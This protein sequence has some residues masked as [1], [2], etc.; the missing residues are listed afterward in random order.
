MRLC[1]VLDPQ[2]RTGRFFRTL[3]TSFVHLG[4]ATVYSFILIPLI[5]HF[6]NTEKLGLW[7]LVA[8]MGAYLAVVDAG[9]SA[10]SIR[11]FV[12]PVSKGN[13]VGLTPR[14]QAT[15]VLSLAQ[16]LVVCLIGLSGPWFSIIFGISDQFKDLFCHLFLAQCVLVGIG[17][18]VRPFSSVL[19]AAQ[20]FDRNYL[21]SSAAFFCALLLTAWGFL[22]GWGLWSVILGSALQTLASAGAS[23]GGVRRMCRLSLLFT[24]GHLQP[25]LIFQIFRESTFF[26]GGSIFST[27]GGLWQSV[28]LSRIFGLEAVAAWNVGAKIAT[29]FSQIL[30]KFF[31]SAFAG[32][33]ELEERQQRSLVMERFLQI[34]LPSLT[35]TTLLS[36]LILLANKSFISWWT[37]GAINWPGCATAAVGVWL[38]SITLNRA[39]AVLVGVLLLWRT[40]RLAP[41]I[42][43]VVFVLMS[44][45]AFWIKDF[46]TFC[47]LVG[48]S[49]IFG[50]VMV[51]IGALSGF[52]RSFP[53]LAKYH[54][55]LICF[56]FACFCF[57]L[58]L[59]VLF[60]T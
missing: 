51:Y 14:F 35:L 47:W 9:L 7:L 4:S 42:D 11:Q 13:F 10:L 60:R 59:V 55:Q 5:L 50:G 45:L 8:Q 20:R 15:F 49:P 18:P 24:P 53:S 27:L 58:L 46:T 34:F 6:G 43:F 22:Q 48:I 29:V 3:F 2:T 38:I 44:S 16:G 17:F 31:E 23:I 36:T 54:I 52:R 56:G 33:S 19:L 25:G 37:K 28:L 32:L 21:I 26:A 57:L 41:M 40:I 12:G 30:S 1:L 39:L